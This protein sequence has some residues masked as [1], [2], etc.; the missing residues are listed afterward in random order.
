[1][2]ARQTPEGWEDEFPESPTGDFWGSMLHFQSVILMKIIFCRPDRFRDLWNHGI[3][4]DQ[5]IWEISVK[6]SLFRLKERLDKFPPDKTHL[7]WGDLRLNEFAWK[8]RQHLWSVGFYQIQWLWNSPTA[9][10][11]LFLM[12]VSL[13]PQKTLWENEFFFKKNL[14][15]SCFFFEKWVSSNDALI[16]LIIFTNFVNRSIVEGLLHT[17]PLQGSKCYSPNG[18]GWNVITRISYTVLCWNR[19]RSCTICG[20]MNNNCSYSHSLFPVSDCMR[21]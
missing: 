16:Y 21:R 9:Q 5:L 6:K 8:T 14:Q 19:M 10:K 11:S 13:P 4:H 2:G 17:V 3:N 12:A 20:E 18:E 7:K 15:F 1:M